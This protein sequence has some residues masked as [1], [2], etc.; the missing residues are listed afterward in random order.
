M[1]LIEEHFFFNWKRKPTIKTYVALGLKTQYFEDNKSHYLINKFNV[2]SVQMQRKHF[3][4]DM[5]DFIL[6][7]LFRKKVL[8]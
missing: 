7:A 4:L 5:L 3:K 2:I 6:P 8:N 1:I